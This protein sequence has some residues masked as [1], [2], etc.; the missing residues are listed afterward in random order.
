MNPVLMQ[1]YAD[2]AVKVGVNVKPGQ[3]FIIQ[4]PV[5]G[6][7]FARACAKAGYEAG[8]KRVEVRYNDEK[9]SR[10]Q[11]EHGD[12]AVLCDVKPWLLRS[13]LDYAED[14]GSVCILNIV[15]RD[16]EIYKGL[17]GEK[18]QKAMLA[19]RTALKPWQEYLSLIHISEPTRL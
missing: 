3:N 15:A 16:P 19:Q 6:A 1:K 9:V 18:I 7:E 17:D 5:D 2:F 11:M 4:C 8:A 14:E 10:L 13:Y 12:E